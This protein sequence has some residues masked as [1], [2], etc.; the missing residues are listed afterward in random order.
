MNK[1]GNKKITLY[2][3][4]FDSKKEGYRYCELL[5][6]QRRGEIT[7]LECQKQYILIP[8]QYE[9]YPRFGK[10]GKRL[11]DGRHCIEKQCA[12]YA[13]FCYFTKDGNYVVEDV[14]GHQD[15]ESATY[16]K[17]VI[18]RKLMLERYGIR[19]KEV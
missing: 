6:M 19:I 5:Q 1:C 8:A 2:G 14:K 3:I 9:T 16:A 12:Y 18:K 15:P 13:D 11:K 17:Y 10:T 4:T 7:G